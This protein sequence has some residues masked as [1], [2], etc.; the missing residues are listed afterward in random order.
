MRLPRSIWVGGVDVESY[1][2]V[3]L[4]GE[5]NGLEDG[6][7]RSL[8]QRRGDACYV[9]RVRVREVRQDVVER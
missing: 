6:I 8:A 2:D 9:E 3:V 7:A 4:T 1:G 5:A